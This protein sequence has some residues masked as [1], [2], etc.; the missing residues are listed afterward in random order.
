[1]RFFNTAGPCD[2]GTLI[3]FDGRSQAPP[4]PERCVQSEIEH[5]ERH[6]TLLRL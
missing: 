5:G 3:L 4:L 6:V 1:M 2:P